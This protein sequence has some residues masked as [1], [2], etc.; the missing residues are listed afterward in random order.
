MVTRNELIRWLKTFPATEHFAVD[1]GGLAIVAV[2]TREGRCLPNE[3]GAYIEIGGMP[4]PEDPEPTPSTT[5]D[6][7]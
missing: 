3:P 7:G 2:S 5:V 4:E 1:E 6:R